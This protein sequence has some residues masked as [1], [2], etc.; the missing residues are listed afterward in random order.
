M[1]GISIIRSH[2]PSLR[3]LIVIITSVRLLQGVAE[4]AYITAIQ[5]ERT[6]VGR[7]DAEPEKCAAGYGNGKNGGHWSAIRCRRWG[8]TGYQ[9][10]RTPI[11]ENSQEK[12][13]VFA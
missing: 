12:T 11:T 3:P 7:R 4:S 5:P 1:R 9:P 10:Q 2:I 13:E 8:Q 6:F